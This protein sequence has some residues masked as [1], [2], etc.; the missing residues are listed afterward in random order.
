ML[1]QQTGTVRRIPTASGIAP[2]ADLT[3]PRAQVSSLVL[4]THLTAGEKVCDGRNRL[5][6]VTG[7]RTDR[8]DKVAQ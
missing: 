6:V 5:S 8:E 1:R 7:A 4:Q 3:N 2:V